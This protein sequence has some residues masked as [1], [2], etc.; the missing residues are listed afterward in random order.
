VPGYKVP[1][2][3][4]STGSGE[5]CNHGHYYSG[6][7]GWQ[8]VNL[9]SEQWKVV[10]SS[11]DDMPIPVSWCG[12]SEYRN[13]SY[14]R[15]CFVINNRGDFL[16]P[17]SFG[18]IPDHPYKNNLQQYNN[19]IAHSGYFSGLAIVYPIEEELLVKMVSRLNE[20]LFSNGWDQVDIDIPDDWPN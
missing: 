17:S 9:S 20:V 6:V 18:G 13:G 15:I 7:G 10:A 12:R 8:F 2:I 3:I 4:P 19:Y 16:Y 1:Y 5:N 14:K 11:I